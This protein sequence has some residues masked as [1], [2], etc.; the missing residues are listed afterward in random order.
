MYVVY[1]MAKEELSLILT[2]REIDFIKITDNNTFINCICPNL[3]N[4]F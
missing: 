2:L 4:T 3:S 1:Y